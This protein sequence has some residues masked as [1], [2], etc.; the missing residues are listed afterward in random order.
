LKKLAQW[1]TRH[2]VNEVC[3]KICNYLE[4]HTSRRTTGTIIAAGDAIAV[5]WMLD[6]RRA[7]DEDDDKLPTG[8]ASALGVFSTKDWH[9]VMSHASLAE[10]LMTEMD[11]PEWEHLRRKPIS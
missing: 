10:S 2:A 4:Q 9:E 7:L 11:R 6:W 8:I 1:L 5:S 3:Y